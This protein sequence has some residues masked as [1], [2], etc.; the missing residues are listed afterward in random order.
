MTLEIVRKTLLSVDIDVESALW[1]GLPEAD[2]AVR[3][4]I[5][6][7]AAELDLSEEG[8]IGVTLTDDRAIEELNRRWRGQA[9]PTNVLSFPTPRSPAPG[10]PRALGDIVLAFE[11]I[12]SE[13]RVQGKP[14]S[15]HVAH[16]VVHGLLHL[17][18][19]DHETD[20]EARSMEGLEIRILASLGIADPY[21]VGAD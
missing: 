11:T 10:A 16:L 9:K 21:A 14:V 18:G 13:A 2:A 19:Y 6:A 4:S 17:L 3:R 12:E 15:A 7:V 20:I 5:A 1:E 8:E